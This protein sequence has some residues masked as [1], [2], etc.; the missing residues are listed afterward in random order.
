MIFQTFA[1]FQLYATA[2]AAI[3]TELIEQTWEERFTWKIRRNSSGSVISST[4]SA[5]LSPCG[6]K[7]RHPGSGREDQS[8]TTE[9]GQT[10]KR[11][12][13]GS[14]S[15]VLHWPRDVQRHSRIRFPFARSRAPIGWRESSQEYVMFLRGSRPVAGSCTADS[16]QKRPRFG[17]N[18]NQ[19]QKKT[20]IK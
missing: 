1:S 5:C 15:S 16:H 13:G 12:K 14:T 3:G 7:F 9:Y 20:R 2:V 17:N 10:R 6:P 4:S 8:R 18:A 19:T 11:H